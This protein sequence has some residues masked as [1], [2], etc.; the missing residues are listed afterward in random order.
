VQR[1]HPDARLQNPG[2]DVWQHILCMEDYKILKFHMININ[3]LRIHITN[4][5]TADT[6]ILQMV[7]RMELV[8]IPRVYQTLILTIHRTDINF[9]MGIHIGLFINIQMFI[10]HINMEG[11]VIKVKMLAKRPGTQSSK[12]LSV[13]G[14]P[15][16]ESE[17]FPQN[18]HNNN[19]NALV[20]VSI[21]SCIT[22]EK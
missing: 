12:I 19:S 20:F 1:F 11:K 17:R 21:L 7:I 13:N 10:I 9:Q 8:V 22:A 2:S 4:I 5:L 14:W 3:T 15:S 16:S 18:F 6:F